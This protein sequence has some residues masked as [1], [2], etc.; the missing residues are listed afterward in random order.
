MSAYSKSNTGAVALI[1]FRD[2]RELD[3]G[4]TMRHVHLS[5]QVKEVDLQ[6][7]TCARSHYFIV[8][9]GSDSGTTP[10]VSEMKANAYCGK[11]FLSRLMN[12]LI[13]E[14]QRG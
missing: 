14:L 8:M 5:M 1:V 6:E 12:L 10:S 2:P 13:N 7:L 3:C 4:T 11:S 9:P